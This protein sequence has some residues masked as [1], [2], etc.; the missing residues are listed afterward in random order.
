MSTEK[1]FKK[2]QNPP[3]SKGDVGLSYFLI[4]PKEWNLFQWCYAYVLWSLMWCGLINLI[5]WVFS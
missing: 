1:T 4:N 5:V 2:A 3:L